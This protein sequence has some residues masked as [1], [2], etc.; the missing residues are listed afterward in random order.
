MYESID[1]MEITYMCQIICF[2][3]HKLILN[4]LWNDE[5]R[6]NFQENKNYWVHEWIA[7]VSDLMK[8]IREKIIVIIR[9]NNGTC[10][11]REREKT[12]RVTASW[13]WEGGGEESKTK[14]PWGV[15]GGIPIYHKTKTSTPFVSLLSMAIFF[16]S[17]PSRDLT[18]WFPPFPLPPFSSNAISPNTPL[19]SNYNLL[20]SRT[21]SVT[22]SSLW[23]TV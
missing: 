19:I 23:H 11:E 6:F 18:S 16:T 13:W 2:F 4:Y 17:T 8:M 12:K 14:A 10:G 3:F 15:F 7:K 9:A 5:K 1:A 22:I 21:L 20:I